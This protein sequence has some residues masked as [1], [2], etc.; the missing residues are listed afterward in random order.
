[1]TT[2]ATDSPAALYGNA[3]LVFGVLGLIT[4][5]IVGYVGLAFPVLFGA[6]G[7]TFG[8]LGLAKRLHRARCV[9]GLTTGAL[10]LLYLVFLLF[11]FG[12]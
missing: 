12:G 5:V 11:T 1:M 7:V 3:S 2:G 4:A 9:T 6:L 8:A 10:A